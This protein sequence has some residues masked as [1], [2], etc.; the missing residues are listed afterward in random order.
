MEN[1]NQNQAEVQAKGVIALLQLIV[2]C[3][4]I[5]YSLYVLMSF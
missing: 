3:V 5:G 4:S 2:A 1:Q